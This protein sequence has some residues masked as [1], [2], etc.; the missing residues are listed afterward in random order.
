MEQEKIFIIRLQ[1]E[2]G[3]YLMKQPDEV[4]KILALQ[5]LGLGF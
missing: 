1:N 5:Q 3:S 4:S 2:N